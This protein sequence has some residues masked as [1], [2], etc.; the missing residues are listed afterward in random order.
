MNLRNIDLNLLVTL[1]ALLAEPNVTRASRRLHL[2][3]PAVSSQ[4]ARLRLVF[5]DPLLVPAANGRGMTPTPRALELA[6]PLREA[7]HDLEAAMYGPAMFDPCSDSRRFVIATTDNG[8]VTLGLPLVERLRQ[9]AGPGIQLAFVM[10]QAQHIVGQLERGEVDLLIGS[11]HMLPSALKSRKLYDERFVMIQRKRHPRGRKP[12]TLKAYC[13]LRHVLC[14]IAGGSFHGFMDEH[15]E[16]LGQRRNVVLSLQSFTLIP[17]LVAGSDYVATLPQ[18]IAERYRDQ[19]DIFEL[20]FPARGFSMF[21]AWHARSHADPAHRWLR[22]QL[23]GIESV[24][25][26]K[27]PRKTATVTRARRASQKAG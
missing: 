21:A 10:V 25:Q 2:S 13:S 24:P 11:R 22:G 27:K 3:Q 7:L 9:L 16:A 1:D 19:L 8:I 17:E 4:L 15:L 14:S 26:R 5:D 12:L 20:P 6:E 23:L 18:K